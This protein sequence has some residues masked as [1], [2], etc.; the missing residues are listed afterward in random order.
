MMAAQRPAFG[1]GVR[2]RHEPDG[3]AMLLVPEGAL[4]L[5]AAAAATLSL[6]DG[7]RTV[8]DIVAALVAQ[9]DVTPEQARADVE[10]LFERL[11]ERRLLVTA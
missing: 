7:T 1:K 2:M 11:C 8:D 3:S 9:F 6:V 4:V 5:N 10:A